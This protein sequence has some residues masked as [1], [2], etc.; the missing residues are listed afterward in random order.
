[1]IDNRV[2]EVLA[3]E[4]ERCAAIRAQDFDKLGKL[5]HP[6]LVHVHTR[7]NQ[8]TRDSYLKYL[9]EVVEMLDV[10]RGALSVA[11]YGECAV[12]TGRL[13]NTARARGTERVVNVEAQA[14]QVWVREEGIWR[15]VAFQATPIGNPPPQ[16][17]P[18]GA[19]R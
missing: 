12:V 7:G 18:P 5:L 4:T 13:Y 15:Q 6:S 2:S 3:A 16:V 10:K 19:S 1:M 17:P 11:I 9:A 8:D 14:M